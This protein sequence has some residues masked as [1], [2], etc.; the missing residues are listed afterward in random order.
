METPQF[1][2]HQEN[3]EESKRQLESTASSS[4]HK[5]AE[6]SVT[7][8]YI[9][10]PWSERG[11]LARMVKECW[12]GRGQGRHTCWHSY[13][14]FGQPELGK[15]DPIVNVIFEAYAAKGKPDNIK[16]MLPNMKWYCNAIICGV[17][18]ADASGAE[19]YTPETEPRQVV[20]GFTDA[21]WR[22]LT[23]QRNAPG[24]G[25]IYDP[26][27]AISVIVTRDDTQEVTKYSVMLAGSK[28]KGVFTPERTNLFEHF[29]SLNAGGSAKVVEI[30]QNLNDLEAKWPMP[31]EEAFAEATV[32]ANALKASLLNG[33]G[34]AAP[35]AG[36]G[37]NFGGGYPGSPG[38]FAPPGGAVG[39]GFPGGFQPGQMPGGAPPQ[40]APIQQAP[41]VQPGA[42]PPQQFP[43]QQ[44]PVNSPAQQFP[45]QTPP[46]QQPA[47]PPPQ[48]Q[49]QQPQA[50]PQQQ[51]Q[52]PQAPAQQAPP[53]QQVTP[54]GA[55]QVNGPA[56]PA[57]PAAPGAPGA[58]TA[59][60]SGPPGRPGA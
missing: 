42:Q 25:C 47:A 7:Y 22:E 2:M 4:F 18:K 29:E 58:P 56:A 27:Q 5:F 28:S 54:P 19:Q 57:A 34:T 17:S 11:L 10:P 43:G 1:H 32:K 59:P 12:L 20:I 26:N 8:L 36:A 46:A 52:Q 14:L 39:G 24:I 23:K 21:M 30:L 48:Q 51:Y 6:N 35:G 9:L 31:G 3:L 49:Y 41:G 37:A 55:P 45:P 60:P 50:P 15:K 53:P 16:K 13:E 38:G 44:P 33:S 40:Q